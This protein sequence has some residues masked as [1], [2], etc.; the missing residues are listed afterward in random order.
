MVVDRRAGGGGRAA[1]PRPRCG[2]SGSAPPRSPCPPRPRPPSRSWDQPRAGSRRPASPVAER[3]RSRAPGRRHGR[4]GRGAHGRHPRSGLPARFG[5]ETP[6]LA[7]EGPR[8]DEF[9]FG[10][11]TSVPVARSTTRVPPVPLPAAGNPWGARRRRAAARAGAA[12]AYRA[13]SR[14]GW[15]GFVLLV[16]AV[17]VAAYFVL[18]WYAYDNWIVTLQ[19]DQIVVKQGQS[20]GVLWFHPKVVDRTGDTTAQIAPAAVAPLRAGVPE[21]SLDDARHVRHRARRRPPPRPPPR[22]RPRPRRR[23]DPCTT[24]A[25]A[26]PTTTTLPATATTTRTGHRD[27]GTGDDHDGG[28]GPVTRVDVPRRRRRP[29]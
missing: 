26:Q 11:A 19:G 29:A 6:T 25:P 3:H 5:D 27:H 22:R 15:S 23:P 12:W 4:H 24:A 10:T 13:A 20:G 2:R 17:P 21:A 28:G 7:A 9:F 1:T 18:R 14:R 16:A 8:S